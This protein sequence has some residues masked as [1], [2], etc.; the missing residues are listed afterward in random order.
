MRRKN[1]FKNLLMAFSITAFV[2]SC[3]QNDEM[4]DTQES[5]VTVSATVASSSDPSAR[6][7]TLSY[8]N[9]NITDVTM[10]VDRV[11]L[12]LRATSAD[13]KKPSI[14]HINNAEPQIL[15]LVE[16]G[17]IMLSPIG[18]VSAY[19]GIYGKLDFDLVK[20][21]D[22]AEDDEMYGKSVLVKGNWFDIPATMYIDL[23]ETFKI[24][25]PQG[26]E[27]D[28]AKEVVFGLYLDRF[29]EGVDPSLI[30]DGDGDGII[31]VGPYGEDGNDETYASF[32]ENIESALFLKDGEFKNKK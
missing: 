20:A 29:F 26:L 6:M 11:L 19:N 1:T 32:M 5:Q 27:V 16:D 14:V 21:M 28:G 9:L 22:V 4:P 24:M 8:G 7:S 30:S 13:S 15:K 18:S 25:F 2:A 31:E 17:E 10:S 23:E 12:N 3:S